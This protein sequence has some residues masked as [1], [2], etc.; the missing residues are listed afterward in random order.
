MRGKIFMYLFVFAMLLVVF[1]YVNSKNIFETYQDKMNKQI[2]REQ[3]LKDSILQLNQE[4][5][6]LKSERLVE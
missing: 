6:E 3:V 5:L 2:E 1:Q 4:L